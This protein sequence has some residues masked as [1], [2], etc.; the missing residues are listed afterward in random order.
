MSG[1]MNKSWTSTK[2]LGFVCC[3]GRNEV[4]VKKFTLVQLVQPS[5]SSWLNIAAQKLTN[6][7][8][9]SLRNSN[10]GEGSCWKVQLHFSHKTTE[11]CCCRALN[12]GENFWFSA[13][14]GWS[15]VLITAPAG[16]H[17][18]LCSSSWAGSGWELE[19]PG[20]HRGPCTTGAALWCRGRAA[21]TAATT[22]LHF[23]S[24]GLAWHVWGVCICIHICIHLCVFIWISVYLYLY[25]HFC[26]CS[27]WQMVHHD[28][29]S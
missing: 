23:N 2:L 14:A 18:A 17:W 6:P 28:K 29:S 16:H 12:W 8:P 21:T 13:A 24:T 26:I 11:A 19:Q 9:P 3:I 15:R 22:T 10:W 27:W 20:G 1:S 25:L 7:I 4:D 5:G